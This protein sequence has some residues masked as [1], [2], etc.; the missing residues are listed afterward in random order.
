METDKV[1][2]G[3]RKDSLHDMVKFSGNEG[4]IVWP[5]WKNDL[6]ERIRYELGQ[7]AVQIVEGE[8]KKGDIRRG[9]LYDSIKQ[10]AE[11]LAPQNRT[12]VQTNGSWIEVQETKLDRQFKHADRKNARFVVVLGPDEASSGSASLK[13]LKTGEQSTLKSTELAERIRSTLAG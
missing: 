8:L 5:L 4:A 3:A 12:G 9:A 13:D 6:M 10:I 11:M 2:M 7:K 1:V